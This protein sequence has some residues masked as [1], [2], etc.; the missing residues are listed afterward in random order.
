MENQTLDACRRLANRANPTTTA[1]PQPT[2]LQQSRIHHVPPILG[3]PGPIE[4]PCST[5]RS[6]A[7]KKIMKA[8]GVFSTLLGLKINTNELSVETLE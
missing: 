7:F 4:K 3:Y 8:L 1:P 2:Y 6:V 5:P